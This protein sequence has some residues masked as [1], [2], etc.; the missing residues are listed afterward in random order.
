MR[1]VSETALRPFPLVALVL[2]AIAR[3]AELP[4]IAGVRAVLGGSDSLGGAPTTVGPHAHSFT[5]TIPLERRA[6]VI[7]ARTKVDFARSQARSKV[8]KKTI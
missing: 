5:I 6:N 3:P 1:G 4:P 7:R 8:N 2:L